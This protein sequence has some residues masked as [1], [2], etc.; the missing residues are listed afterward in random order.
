MSSTQV[1]ADQYTRH[2][3]YLLRYGTGQ[4]NEI[5]KYL[6]RAARLIKERLLEA[7]TEFKVDRFSGLAQS[8]E[9]IYGQMSND[10]RVN[11]S[12]FI[13][14]EVTYNVNTIQANVVASVEVITPNVE[15]LLAAAT[16]T[17]ITLGSKTHDLNTIFDDFGATKARTVVNDLRLGIANGMSNQEL[18]TFLKGVELKTQTDAKTLVR[19]LTNHVATDTRL[20]VL[21]ANEDIVEGFRVVAT[22][23][24]KTTFI[25]ASKDNQVYSLDEAKPPYHPNCRSTMSPAIKSKYSVPRP[26][27]RTARG[28]DGKTKLN[29]NES[30]PT[31][32]KRQPADFQRE[33]FG[34][35]RYQ[36]WKQG[37]LDIKKFVDYDDRVLSLDE[38]RA[39]EPEAFIKAGL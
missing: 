31:W 18:L 13:E 37:K 2:Q 34:D 8:L 3:L 25:C 36:L 15:Q 7:D 12:K 21:E 9:T 24:S 35:T 26:G 17:K 10:V 29:V 22:L 16:N 14:S 11:L 30:F 27:Y 33:Y 4:Y 19:T 39:L 28:P 32:L 5:K 20:K 38:L 6:D 1:L 23:D